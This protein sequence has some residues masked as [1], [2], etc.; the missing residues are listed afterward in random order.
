MAR[1]YGD[2]SENHEYKA[3]KEMQKL[4][5][6]R[7]ADLETQLVRARGTD[8]AIP[9]TD[10]A[11]IGTIVHATDLATNQAG[12]LHHP[13][14]V[15]FGPGERHCQLPLARRPIIAGPQGRV[16]RSSSRSTGSGTTIASSPFS[17]LSLLQP[18]LPP[19]RLPR[20]AG[21][22][23][24]GA[25][26]WQA[27]RRLGSR[28]YGKLGILRCVD[29]SRLCLAAERHVVVHVE[30]VEP[31]GNVLALGRNLPVHPVEELA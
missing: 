31:G 4:L 17:R 2:L 15:G 12:A 8:F 16:T 26:K 29:H 18:P 23:T 22:Q 9:R 25:E 24:C 21:F 28:Q 19:R 1:S 6:R 13:R 27:P 14:R 30:Q 3:A 7:K 20:N 10:V 11:S 5:M